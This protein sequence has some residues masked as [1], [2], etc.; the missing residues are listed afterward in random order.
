ML[1]AIYF[2]CPICFRLSDKDMYFYILSQCQ[3]QHDHDYKYHYWIL[4]INGISQL[5]FLLLRLFP[6]GTHDGADKVRAREG[7]SANPEKCQFFLVFNF[8]L[9]KSFSFFLKNLGIGSHLVLMWTPSSSQLHFRFTCAI[10]FCQV[11]RP[12]ALWKWEPPSNRILK[13]SQKVKQILQA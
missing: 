4:F 12:T 10:I 11:P 1:I 8:L 9:R 3:F 13:I 5:F 2:L 6:A 7:E